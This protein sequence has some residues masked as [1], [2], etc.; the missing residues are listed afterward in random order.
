MIDNMSYHQKAWQEFLR[1]YGI[2]LSDEEFKRKISGK[3][4]DAIFEI[5]FGRR[6]DDQDLARYAEEKEALYRELYYPYIRELP[7]LSKTIQTL[8]DYGLRTAIA[9]TAPAR[10]REFGLQ[11]LRLEDKFEV[12]LGDEHVA[13]GKPDPE[14][15]LKTAAQLGVEPS[16]CIVFE[17]SPGGVQS[18]KAAGMTVVGILSS[19][20]APELEQADYIV[21]NFTDLSFS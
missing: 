8:Q 20:T 16:R 5:V 14:I 21:N 6:L 3:K 13:H 1:R 18:A 11:R 9:T 12:I 19:H 4:N 10:N 15:Y 17:D 7:G 2:Q